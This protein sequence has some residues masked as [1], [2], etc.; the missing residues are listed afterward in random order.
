V[1][2][3]DHGDMMASHGMLNKCVMYDEAMRVPLILRHPGLNAGRRI[4]E[5]ANHVDLVPSLLEAVG[6]KR[7]GHLQGDS[8][9]PLVTGC[10]PA[11]RE[12]PV[13]AE[14][15]DRLQWMHQRHA[16]FA[17]VQARQIRTVR[18]PEW[19]LNANQEDRWELYH[20]ASDP[21]EMDNRIDDPDCRSVVDELSAGLRAW[22]KRTADHA[23]IA[24]QP[25]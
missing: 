16:L 4:E 11:R 21:G 9:W 19:K 14:W 18:T 3:S 7:P 24:A 13:F 23:R 15:C 22:Q 10:R 12:K 5:S 20:L 25:Q 6:V 17:P 8:L 1:F 2:T